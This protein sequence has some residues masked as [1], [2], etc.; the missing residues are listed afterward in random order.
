MFLFRYKKDGLPLGLIRVHEVILR[1]TV[2]HFEKGKDIRARIKQARKAVKKALRVAKKKNINPGIKIGMALEE[3]EQIREELEYTRKSLIATYSKLS[4]ALERIQQE[5]IEKPVSLIE[6]ARELFREKHIERGIE[7][8][9]KS[10]DEMGKKVLLKT[11]SAV[12]GGISNEVK[13]LKRE[14]EQLRK[15]RRQSKKKKDR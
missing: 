12:F 6:N 7:K 3:F 2:E 1:D 8:L 10:R 9:K 13:D 14:I 11:R 4:D 15:S 5:R